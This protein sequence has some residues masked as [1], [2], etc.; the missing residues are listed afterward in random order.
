MKKFFKILFLLILVAASMVGGFFIGKTYQSTAMSVNYIGQKL[1]MFC[2]SA[3]WSSNSASAKASAAH[4]VDYAPNA[5]NYN[6]YDIYVKSYVLFAK[7]AFQD[8]ELISSTHYF[9]ESSY[10]INSNTYN[11]KMGMYFTIDR[12]V[13]NIWIHDFKTNATILIKLESQL[14]TNDTGV[15]QIYSYSTFKNKNGIAYAELRANKE[16]VTGFSYSEIETEVDNFSTIEKINI[17]QMNI[18]DCDILSRKQLNLSIS[19]LTDEEIK[20]YTAETIKKF[21]GVYAISFEQGS[22][23]SIDALD[24]LYKELGYK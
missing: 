7:I 6:G 4:Y 15:M 17:A 23:R 20:T 18:Y 3:G 19:D 13:A 11:G 5:V 1:D 8:K 9:S 2:N 12:N 21:D 14:Q 10:T 16:K 22:Y 24:K